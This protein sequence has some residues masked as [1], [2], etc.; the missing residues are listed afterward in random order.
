MPRPDKDIP[1]SRAVGRFFGHLWNA[2]ARPV[3]PSAS[4]GHAAGGAGK[5][6][7][8]ETEE[9]RGEIDGKQVVLRRTTIEEVEF[10]DPPDTP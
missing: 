4:A 5:T 8:H 6:V 3:P 7:R 2:A 1:I 10:R 9:S